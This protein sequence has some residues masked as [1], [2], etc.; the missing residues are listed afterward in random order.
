MKRFDRA[1]YAFF[2]LALLADVARGH[3]S[4]PAGSDAGGS[5]IL[6]AASQ[7]RVTPAGEATPAP[8][9]A[10]GAFPSRL[11]SYASRISGWA[12]AL[13]GQPDSSNLVVL[14]VS[15]ADPDIGASSPHI[16]FL[17]SASPAQGIFEHTGSPAP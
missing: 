15:I 6:S 13:A 11:R 7:L 16:R 17:Q 9:R 10:V 3:A 1:M 4:V 14:A 5:A 8:R 12:R 2:L